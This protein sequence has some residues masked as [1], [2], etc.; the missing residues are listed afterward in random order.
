MNKKIIWIAV[1][2]VVILVSVFLLKPQVSQENESGSVNTIE[3]FQE[4]E[5]DEQVFSAI[6]ES[7]SY[8]D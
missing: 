7:L 3:S 6:E 1:V 8:I 4:L 5:T 2:F